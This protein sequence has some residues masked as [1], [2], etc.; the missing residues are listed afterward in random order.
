[1]TK[2]AGSES[3]DP[4][5]DPEPHQNVIDPQHYFN[6]YVY[7]SADYFVKFPSWDH[8]SRGCWSSASTPIPIPLLSRLFFLC[9]TQHGWLNAFGPNIIFSR[10]LSSREKDII[11]TL[12]KNWVG[13]NLN[14]K[15]QCHKIFCFWFFS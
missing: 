7:R 3:T 9:V 2:I 4:D 12:R 1:M 14:L 13:R 11:E 8:A 15:G 6:L 10:S 5:S